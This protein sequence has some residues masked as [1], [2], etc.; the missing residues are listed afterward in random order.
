MKKVLVI[1]LLL[2]SMLHADIFL[3]GGKTVG[4][5]LGSGSVNYG[6]FKGTENY[7]ILGVSGSYFV[8]DDLSVG[9]GYRHWFG[10]SP[11]IDE[12]TVPVTYFVPIHPKYRPYGGVF[13]RRVF[14]GDGFDDDSVYGVRAGLTVRLSSRSYFGVGWVQEYYDDCSGRDECSSGYPEALFSFSF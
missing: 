9:L 11:S 1:T 8:M 3:K 14:M 4:V 7:T 2:L 13:Y 12:V 10:G 6:R 5:T